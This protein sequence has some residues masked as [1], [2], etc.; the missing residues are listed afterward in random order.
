M[1][2]HAFWVSFGINMGLS[3]VVCVGHALRLGHR[4]RSR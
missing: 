1:M 2:S 4:R 3:L